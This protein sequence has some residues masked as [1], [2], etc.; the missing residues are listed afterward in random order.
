MNNIHLHLYSIPLYSSTVYKF[1]NNSLKIPGP[2]NRKS[3]KSN[4]V[5]VIFTCIVYHLTDNS[6]NVFTIHFDI[7]IL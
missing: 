6:T 4:T 7:K 1:D 5:L 2:T 3:N